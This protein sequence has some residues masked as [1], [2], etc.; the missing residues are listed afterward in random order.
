MRVCSK[1]QLTPISMNILKSRLFLFHWLCFMLASPVYLTGQINIDST[2]DKSEL[3]RMLGKAQESNDRESLAAVY[4]LLA[5]YEAENF[6]RIGNS[7]DNY[8]QAKNYYNRLQ[9]SFMVSTIDRAIGLKYMNSG[10]YQEAMESYE[11][12][13]DYFTKKEDTSRELM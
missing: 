3:D 10:Y 6:Y 4:Y 1:L 7:L 9:D 13:L 5:E 12:A 8:S 11:K 2:Y